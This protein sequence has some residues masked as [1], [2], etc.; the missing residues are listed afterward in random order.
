[1]LFGES[2][3][4]GE[5]Q[6]VLR[7]DKAGPAIFETAA[8]FPISESDMSSSQGSH[9]ASSSDPVLL[10]WQSTSQCPL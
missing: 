4:S 10:F 7:V 9:M 8:R 1:M 6:N 2:D 3:S 5:V